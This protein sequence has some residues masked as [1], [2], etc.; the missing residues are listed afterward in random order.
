MAAGAGR[1]EEEASARRARMRLLLE[2]PEARGAAS[3]FTTG[4]GAALGQTALRRGAG[5]VGMGL[6][7]VPTPAWPGLARPLCPSVPVRSAWSRLSPPR[8]PLAA[9]QQ[10]A[11][12]SGLCPAVFSRGSSPRVGAG[13]GPGPCGAAPGRCADCMSFLSP[14]AAPDDR[15]AAQREITVRYVGTLPAAEGPARGRGAAAPAL[16]RVLPPPR[17]CWPKPR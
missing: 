9:P 16:L 11:L 2:H 7:T 8:W 1:E 15:S 3:L 6:G 13:A 4:L 17:P 14:L 10:P 12:A 5:G